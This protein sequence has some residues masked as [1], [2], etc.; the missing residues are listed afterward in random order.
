MLVKLKARFSPCIRIPE[1]TNEFLLQPL[2]QQQ[3]V[4]GNIIVSGSPVCLINSLN[5]FLFSSDSH[6][7]L[8]FELIPEVLQE[9]RPSPVSDSPD[10]NIRK[11]TQ[12]LRTPQLRLGRIRNWG[13]W[14]GDL[15]NLGF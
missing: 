8:D 14:I 1:N 5:S 3:L 15:K 9:P 12:I 7:R 10:Y 2:G 13:G 6:E 4:S 11:Q